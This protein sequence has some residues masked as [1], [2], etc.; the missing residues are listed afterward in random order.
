MFRYQYCMLFEA[1]TQ[2]CIWFFMT[3]STVIH[4]KRELYS[5]SSDITRNDTSAVSILGLSSI[6]T[7]NGY[8][9]PKLLYL[10]N[11]LRLQQW[12]SETLA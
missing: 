2:L 5:E 9:I 12:W 11:A 7:I 10:D 8:E 3:V 6:F 4:D 1:L